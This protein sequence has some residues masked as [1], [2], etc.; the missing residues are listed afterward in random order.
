MSKTDSTAYPGLLQPLPIPE[1]IWSS[2]SMDFIEGLPYSQGKTV[3]MVIVD[4]LSKY[5][6]FIALQHPFTASTIAQVFLDNVYKLHGLPDS[7]QGFEGS[8]KVV[9]YHPQTDG[10]TE[11]V[12]RCFRVLSKVYV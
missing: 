3:I 7:I 1:K 6:H 5:A 11:V 4:R 2:I 10:Q 8:I 12:N 9:Y